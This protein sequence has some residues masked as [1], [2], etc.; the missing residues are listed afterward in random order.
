MNLNRLEQWADAIGCDAAEFISEDQPSDSVIT[1][2]KRRTN[3]EGKE[4]EQHTI[5]NG[6]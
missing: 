2:P 4:K 5:Y 1:Y 6:F 3:L